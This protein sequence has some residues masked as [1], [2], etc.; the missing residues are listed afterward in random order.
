MG[1]NF[2]EVG[3]IPGHIVLDGD[4]APPPRK[5][6]HSSLTH[7]SAHVYCAHLSNCS[8]WDIRADTH[9]HRHLHANRNTY[10]SHP[11]TGGEVTT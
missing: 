11:Y 1:Q 6:G 9:T 10:T 2:D 5:G 8:C 3:L 7:F 4:P